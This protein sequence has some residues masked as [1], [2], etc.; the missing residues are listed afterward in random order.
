MHQLRTLI[1]SSKSTSCTL[2]AIPTRLLKE[3]F[4]LT[5]TSLLDIINLSLEIG[6]VPLSFKT[7]VIKP[8]IKKPSL[9]PDILANY[10]PIYNLVFI[11]KILE[12]VVATQLNDYLNC[13]SLFETFQSGFRANHSTETALVKVTNDLLMASDHGF[14]SV[15]VLLDLS[16]AFDTI[17]HHILLERLENLLG[18]SGT[19]LNWFRSYLTDRYQ[20]V[21]VNDNQSARTRV[22][23]GVPQGSV[24]KVPSFL[25]PS[26]LFCLPCI[27]S[28]WVISSGSIQL[29]STAMLMTPSYISRL[30]LMNIIIFKGLNPV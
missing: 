30:R 3:V 13:N 11:S 28:P 16:A 17:D 23:F 10:R 14:V 6:Y 4:P 18:I 12:R 1:S 7:A 25:P 2:D 27:C 20:F 15:L 21:Q 22:C 5:G 8:I 29:T 24:D 26:F 19:A 9:N